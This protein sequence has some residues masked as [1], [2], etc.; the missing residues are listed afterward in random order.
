MKRFA[1]RRDRL[2]IVLV[3]ATALFVV[4]VARWLAALL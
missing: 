1:W 2:F 3:A 4:E